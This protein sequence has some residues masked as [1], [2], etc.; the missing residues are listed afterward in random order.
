MKCVNNPEERQKTKGLPENK[1]REMWGFPR[2]QRV[3]NESV[4]GILERYSFS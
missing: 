3:H 1:Q 4:N 2:A